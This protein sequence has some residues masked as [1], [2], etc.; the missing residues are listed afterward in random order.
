[1]PTA[2]VLLVAS[3]GGHLAQLWALRPW[4]REHRRIWVT[5]PTP[6]ALHLLAGEDVR[7]AHHPTTRNLA[8][9][10][11]NTLLAVRTLARTRPAAVVTTGAGVAL[12]F[13][14]LAWLL[15]IP[16]VYVE[17]YD[18]IDTPTLTTRL[19]RPFTRLHL[20]QWEEQRAFLPTAI[21][22]GPLL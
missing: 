14:V 10:V 8:N 2:P 4:W 9:L 16:T 12:P 17:V 19:C 3:S 18:R 11:R 1:M 6:D 20:T 5:F 13:F 21:T 7:H 15:R 22:V